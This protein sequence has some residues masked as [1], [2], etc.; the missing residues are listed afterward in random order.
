MP[1][2][3][4]SRVRR[5]SSTFTR[6]EL[7][8]ALEKYTSGVP[9]QHERRRACIGAWIGVEIWTA[10][11]A[12]LCHPGKVEIVDV[13]G[14]Q[15]ALRDRVP[16]RQFGFLLRV[17][18]EAGLRAFN[19]RNQI[20]YQ[21]SLE[22]RLSPLARI[23]T[24]QNRLVIVPLRGLVTHFVSNSFRSPQFCAAGPRVAI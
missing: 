16:V 3:R 6:R 7:S 14:R 19:R 15:F 4:I 22:H 13:E 21:S 18:A 8:I 20:V 11:A 5:G 1:N 17:E 2:W 10:A 23:P 9:T 24:H 12:I